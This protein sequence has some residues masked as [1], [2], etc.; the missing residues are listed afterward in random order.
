MIDVE[1]LIAL[2]HNYNPRTNAVLIR[3]AYAYG[4]QMH[5]GQMRKSGEPYFSHPV[6]VAAILTEQQ[7]DDATI[8]TALLLGRFAQDM[9]F[10]TSPRDP[11]VLVSLSST[12]QDQIALI[13][14]LGPPYQQLLSHVQT[15]GG[16]LLDR[17]LDTLGFDH[18][19]L[20]A[21]LLA[22]WGLPPG[23]CAAISVPPDESRIDDLTK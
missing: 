13:Q 5:D 3:Q 23:L 17:E 20:S 21:R 22:H 9:L 1:D 8:I 6:A 2:V 15:Q 16:S 12:Y 18:L 11:L 7:L 4:M 10:Q 14:R 19:V